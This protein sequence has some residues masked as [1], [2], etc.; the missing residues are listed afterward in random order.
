MK[1]VY[2]SLS[3][4]FFFILHFLNYNAVEARRGDVIPLGSFIESSEMRHL[5]GSHIDRNNYDYD[6]AE[7][8][9]FRKRKTKKKKH[10]VIKNS[11]SQKNSLQHSEDDEKQRFKHKGKKRGSK[12][13]IKTTLKNVD[14]D[15][16]LSDSD[17]NDKNK[18]PVD[19]IVHIKMKE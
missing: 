17:N 1:N 10:K 6:K 4:L 14:K 13:F 9:Q 7:F 5:K 19:I 16:N 2:I 8:P 15:S 18:N 3:N 12:R 11:H